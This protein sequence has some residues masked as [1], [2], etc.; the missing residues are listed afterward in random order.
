M[1]VDLEIDNRITKCQKILEMDPNS[2]IFAA[3]AEAYRKKGELEKAFQVCHNGLRLHPNYGA[4]HMVMARVNLDRGLYDWAEA[5]LER[6]RQVDGNSRTIELLLAEIYIYKGEYQAAIRLLKRLAASDPGN[7]HVQRLL[8]IALRIPQEQQAELGGPEPEP[9]PVKPEPVTP[10]APVPRPLAPTRLSP[11]EMLAESLQIGGVGG[12]LYVNSEGLV[13][14]TKWSSKADPAVC[15]AS[16]A[17][18]S[19]FLDQELMKISFGRVGAVLIETGRQV[20]YII[21][22]SGGMFVIMSDANVNL[23]SLRMRMATLVERVQIL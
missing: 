4:A 13:L 16:M 22:V 21:R 11:A 17:E 15:G 7:D 20:F 6:A 23:G 3:L 1:T 18:V 5:E 12:A 14:E 2:Q 19:K 9:E 10:T 8:D